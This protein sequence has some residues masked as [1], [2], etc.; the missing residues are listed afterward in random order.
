MR[1]AQEGFADITCLLEDM[2]G[3]AIEG[4][5]RSLTMDHA[6]V[7]CAIS[8]TGWHKRAGLWRQLV[9]CV[10]PCSP[11]APRMVPHMV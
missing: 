2:H 8:P 6:L 5:H 1:S 3:L 11:D 9:S 4:Q 10:G 7:L